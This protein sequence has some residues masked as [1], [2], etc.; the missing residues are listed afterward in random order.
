MVFASVMAVALSIAAW[1]YRNM[2]TIGGYQPAAFA[3]ISGAVSFPLAH[4]LVGLDWDMAVL[5]FLVLASMA[6]H[7]FAFE[8]G[9]DQASI[10]F[11]V[12]LS[13]VIYVGL[14]GS[15]FVALR[16]LPEGEWWMLVVLTGVWLADTGGFIIGTR[17]GKNKLAPRLSPMKTWE[18]YVG[19]IVFV[20]V[21]MPLLFLLYRKLGLSV[22]STISLSRAMIIGVVMSIFPPLGDLGI[23]MF[24][25]TFKLKDTGAI[26]PGHGGILDRIDSWIWGILIGYFIITIFFI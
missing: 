6:V 18:G 1:E 4:A 26:L 21:G 14:F 19:G 11:V 15:Y 10:D 2:F 12:T 24:K 22:D 17:F 23:S 13:G 9:R 5:A 16:T 8:R 7:M 25:R 20:V 3:L